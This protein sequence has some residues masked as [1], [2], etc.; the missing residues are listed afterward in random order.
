M[1]RF[2]ERLETATGAEEANF[3][4]D[5]KKNVLAYSSLKDRLEEC[6][7]YWK[8]VVANADN[9]AA[10]EDENLFWEDL[11]KEMMKLDLFYNEKFKDLRERTGELYSRAGESDAD[12]TTNGTHL[13]AAN[14]PPPQVTPS[15]CEPLQAEVRSLQ[16]WVELNHIALVKIH[17]KYVKN[18]SLALRKDCGK[19][20]QALFERSFFEGDN[21]LSRLKNW[22]DTYHARLL[23]RT[24]CSLC[25]GSAPCTK[26]EC[27]VTKQRV[28]KAVTT[29]VPGWA[30]VPEEHLLIRVLTG[31]LSNHLYTVDC[32]N[33]TV[34]KSP[35]TSPFTTPKVSPR[36][37]PEDGAEAPDAPPKDASPARVVVRVF[38]AGDYIDRDLECAIAKHLCEMHVGPQTYGAFEGG[39]VE[40]FVQGLALKFYHLARPNILAQVG[41]NMASIHNLIVPIPQEPLVF[42]TIEKYHRLAADVH[43]TPADVQA[44]PGLENAPIPK[45]LLLEKLGN[46]ADYAAEI[47]WLK[48]K[49]AEGYGG[50]G[51]SVCFTHGDMQEGNVLVDD[52]TIENPDITVIDFE[53]ARYD[54]AAFDVANLFCETY[55]DNFFPEYPYF[56]VH[57]QLLISESQQ[58]D[59]IEVYLTARYTDQQAPSVD[60]FHKEVKMMQLASHLQWGLWSVLQSA[61]STIDFCYL[62]YA[63]ARLSEYHRVKRCIMQDDPLLN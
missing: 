52:P 24:T 61:H 4:D 41:I 17:K 50:A 49:V 27:L 29:T 21:D 11:S 12:T 59:F 56:R 15:D 7:R 62:Q 40:E 8:G 39:R 34:H 37:P 60:A 3:S 23:S 13:K 57:P 14:I 33:R 58:R 45:T 16:K 55:I 28:Y 2:G 44:V 53:Y 51:W 32:Y 35:T 63:S 5:M 22:I 18:A 31:G 46:L 1:V 26:A 6:V 43:F 10:G 38:G 9:S 19:N 54:Y 36:E 30:S 20:L 25:Q 42:K 47:E 48:A